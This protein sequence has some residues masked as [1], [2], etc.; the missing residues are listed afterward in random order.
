M[1][2]LNSIDLKFSNSKLECDI[3][4]F[5]FQMLPKMTTVCNKGSIK[6]FDQIVVTIYFLPRILFNSYKNE[7]ILARGTK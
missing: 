1:N 6:L 4:N 7:E 3:Q 5:E 2:G